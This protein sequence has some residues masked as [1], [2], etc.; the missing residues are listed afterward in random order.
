MRDKYDGNNRNSARL[1]LLCLCISPS[2]FFV[3]LTM[4]LITCP[5]YSKRTVALRE[6]FFI[7]WNDAGQ[8]HGT[9]GKECLL[10]SQPGTSCSY[11]HVPEQSSFF[12]F[13]KF[14]F[15][16]HLEEFAYHTAIF[17]LSL[18]FVTLLCSQHYSACCFLSVMQMRTWH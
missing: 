11:F 4:N 10:H 2:Q 13:P 3:P 15:C 17:P 18:F 12:F 7:V 14:V 1:L 8:A 6:I 5:V 16:K 9:L